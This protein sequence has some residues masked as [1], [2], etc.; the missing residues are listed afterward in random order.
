M[1]W[2][3]AMR[4]FDANRLL[5]AVP[6]VCAVGT[7][8]EILDDLD[9][10]RIDGAAVTPSWMV[11]GDPRAA[12][13]FE[14]ASHI[15]PSS[16]R[17]VRIPV[18]IPGVAGSGTPHTPEDLGDVAAVRACPVRHRFELFGATA[19]V[20]WRSLA[21]QGIPLVLDADE[22]GL[23][24]IAELAKAMPD[25]RVLAIH[26]GYRELVRIAE[27][28]QEHP[29]LTVETGTI[30]S[31]GAIEWLART[32]GAHRLIFGTGAPLMDDAGPRYQLERLALTPE[33]ITLIAHGSWD[34]LIGDRA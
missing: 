9:R 7:E 30:V 24:A 20:W 21:E 6:R 12:A 34:L 18:V 14:R 4:V 1:N 22:V 28:M 23:A 5:G 8:S 15:G 10:L 25:L 31:A 16:P 33:D 27:F 3:K 11:Y 29:L 32:L 17:L 2:K 13:E 19:R 26:P